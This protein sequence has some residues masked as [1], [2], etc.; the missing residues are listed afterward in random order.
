MQKTALIDF[1][2]AYANV[3]AEALPLWALS[4]H[5]AAQSDAPFEGRLNVGF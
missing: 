4:G 2:A 1:V 3:N 5:A